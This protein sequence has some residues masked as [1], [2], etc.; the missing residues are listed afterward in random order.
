VVVIIREGVTRHNNWPG[1]N[2][3]DLSLR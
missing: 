1:C 3:F 2:Q